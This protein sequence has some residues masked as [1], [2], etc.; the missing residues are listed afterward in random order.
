MMH[1]AFIRALLDEAE[2]IE[3]EGDEDHVAR[4][5][6]KLAQGDTSVL[7]GS[8]PYGTAPYDKVRRSLAR[9]FAAA[10][11]QVEP[12]PEYGKLCVI[13]AN[14]DIGARMLTC[15]GGRENVERNIYEV[16]CVF[17]VHYQYNDMIRLVEEY[18][19]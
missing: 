18:M 5:L 19:E 2:R 7:P 17:N 10:V 11:P 8:G 16:D 9:A 15:I 13:E 12:H 1:G 14:R 4:Y 6:T 3:A